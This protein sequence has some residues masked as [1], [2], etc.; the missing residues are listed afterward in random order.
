VYEQKRE[1]GNGSEEE[2]DDRYTSALLASE[3]D[4]GV[5]IQIAHRIM[6]EVKALF[7]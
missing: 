4:E 1:D 7:T 3:G 5:N 6:A 2:E